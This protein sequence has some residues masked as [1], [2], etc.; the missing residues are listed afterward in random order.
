M[1]R[2]KNI[3]GTGVLMMLVLP[4]QGQEWLVP[5]NEAATSNPS[6]YTLENVKLGKAI[7]IKNCKS[8]HGD[9]GKNNP[10][11]LVPSPVDIASEKMQI[12]SEGALF[13]KIA[14]G[15]GVMP[16][17]ASTISENDRW[18]LVNFIQ[19]YNPDREQV[20]LDLPPVKAKLLAS[21]NEAQGAV[22]IMAEYKNADSV[23]VPLLNA[24]VSISSKKAF[25]NLKIGETQTND[26][27]RAIYTIPDNT[28]GDEQGYISVV[29]SLSEDYEAAEVILDKA[30]VGSQKEV[31]GLIRKGVLWSTNNNV[32]L[33]VLISYIL[34]AGGAWVV[35][36]YVIVQIVKIKK[37]SRSS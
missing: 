12:N 29:V 6:E 17:F 25:G 28:M 5:E 20:L 21:V 10:L 31:P 8:C 1:N 33:W 24:P 26:Q 23:Y 3:I 35:I 19:N 27:G 18:L 15:K 34:A 11:A 32:S 4:V 14:T 36:I 30:L 2:L 13:Y 22:D 37:Y 7:Y 16:P 9:P